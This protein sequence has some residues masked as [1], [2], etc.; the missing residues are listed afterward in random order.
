MQEEVKQADVADSVVVGVWH[1]VITDD[2]DFS[3]TVVDFQQ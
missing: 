1:Y 2:Y 3:E